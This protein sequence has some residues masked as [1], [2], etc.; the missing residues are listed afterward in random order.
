MALAMTRSKPLALLLDNYGFAMLVYAVGS[1]LACWIL[2]RLLLQRGLHFSDLQFPGTL[3]RKAL[4]QI[5]V[6]SILAP[7]VFGLI[8]AT[9]IPMFWQ[10]TDSS[11]VEY[12]QATA[13]TLVMVVMATC[14]I[15]P[16]T[17]ELLFRGY[18]FSSLRQRM[19]VVAAALVS[20][21][22]FAAL[23]LPF[24]GPGLALYIIPWGLAA[25]YLYTRFSSL[26]APILFH[27]LNN[28]VAYVVAPILF[29]G[30]TP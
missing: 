8:E 12:S 27:L 9:G 4:A 23:H 28:L 1:A 14:C 22:V 30:K 6:A 18:L 5:L 13:P 21:L 3:S 20:S 17:E 19:P 10:E 15:V 26:S 11:P 7:M 25:C 2:W 24:F 16:V 29:S